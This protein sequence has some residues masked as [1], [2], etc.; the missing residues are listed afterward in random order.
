VV[1]YALGLLLRTTAGQVYPFSTYATWL[2]D[3]GFER[4]ERFDLVP[5]P[6]LS[7]ITARRSR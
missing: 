5:S 4:I 2:R 1:L 7:L 3:A 6:P